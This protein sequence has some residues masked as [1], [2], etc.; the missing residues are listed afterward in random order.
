MKSTRHL[1]ISCEICGKNR[2][3]LAK[4]GK[5]L[6]KRCRSCSHLGLRYNTYGEG[7]TYLNGYIMRKIYIDDFFSSMG[8]R[9]GYVPEHRLIM[10]QHLDR[11]LHSWEIVHHK[12]GIKTDNRIE[13]LSLVTR[14]TH[15][16]DVQCPYC[17]R[18][19]QLK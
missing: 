7:L 17:L 12:N 6:N 4:N 9:S 2:H 14:A 8:G 16:G 10:A 18:R 3:V 1:W 5:P 11:C 19:F 13:N 15:Q